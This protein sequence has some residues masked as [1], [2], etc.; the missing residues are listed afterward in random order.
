[1]K[2]VNHGTYSHLSFVSKRQVAERRYILSASLEFQDVMLIIT[3]VTKIM[4][5]Y[6]FSS[7]PQNAELLQA[8]YW[9]YIHTFQIPQALDSAMDH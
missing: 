8:H 6:L 4:T 2:R 3:I 7:L 5:T 9:L 1:M